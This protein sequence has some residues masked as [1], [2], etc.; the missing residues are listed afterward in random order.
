MGAAAGAAA[1]GA[2]AAANAIK[3]SGVVVRMEP[4]DFLALLARTEAPLVVAGMGGLFTKHYR[5]LTSYR[6]LAFFTKSPDPLTL[7]AAAE[8]IRAEA[9]SIPDL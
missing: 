6:G 1:G 2:A 5:Y 4:A 8:V 3:A 9:I 7:P